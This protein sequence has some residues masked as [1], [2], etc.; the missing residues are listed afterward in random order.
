MLF[1]I[2][3]HKIFSCFINAEHNVS[4]PVITTV[5]NMVFEKLYWIA[6]S[7]KDSASILNT[8]HF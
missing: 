6:N 7:Q 4:E 3:N 5:L 8:N 1:L 2:G